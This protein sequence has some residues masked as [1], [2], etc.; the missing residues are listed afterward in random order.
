MMYRWQFIRMLIV[1]GKEI[2]WASI[3][4]LYLYFWSGEES[5][6]FAHTVKIF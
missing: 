4:L 5:V 3:T 2:L 6:Q 1:K